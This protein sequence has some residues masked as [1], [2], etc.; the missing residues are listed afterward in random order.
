M[1]LDLERSSGNIIRGFSGREVTVGNESFREPVIITAERVIPDWSPPPVGELTLGDFAR[2]LELEPEVILLGT[3]VEQ[4]FPSLAV[5]RRLLNMQVRRRTGAPP[6]V[7]APVRHG[8]SYA[9]RALDRLLE[10]IAPGLSDLDHEEL[11]V[12]LALL[13]RAAG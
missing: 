3:G 4:R 9:T 6:P 8:F 11:A 10:S 13:T 1:K 2:L 7:G 5:D 12:R